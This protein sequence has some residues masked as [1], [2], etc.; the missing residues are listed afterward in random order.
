MLKCTPIPDCFHVHSGHGLYADCADVLHNWLRRTYIL[1]ID[2]SVVL[3]SL[4]VLRLILRFSEIQ[5]ERERERERERGRE[6]EN[7]LQCL[8]RF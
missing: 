8:D 3:Q 6:R 2:V 1:I 5:R 7:H 4:A